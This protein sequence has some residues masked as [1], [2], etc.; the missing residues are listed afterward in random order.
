VAAFP[1]TGPIDVLAD[2]SGKIGAVNVDLRA[3]ALDALTA[4]RAACRAHAESYSW[5]VCAEVFLSHLVP[6]A[7]TSQA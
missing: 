2:A 4:D 5:R 3:A 7:G 1:V 6:L